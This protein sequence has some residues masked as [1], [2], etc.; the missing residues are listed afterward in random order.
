MSDYPIGK[1]VRF[2][3]N[4]M[5]AGRNPAKQVLSVDTRPASQAEQPVRPPMETRASAPSSPITLP[6]CSIIETDPE[7]VSQRGTLRET[8]ARIP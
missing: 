8:P 5:A 4:L 6:C 7:R 1:R 2:H 3:Q